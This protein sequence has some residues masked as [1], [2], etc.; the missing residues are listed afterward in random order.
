[1]G[2]CGKAQAEQNESGLPQIADLG[3]KSGYR[4]AAFARQLLFRELLACLVLWKLA[5]SM[6]LNG[7]F[8]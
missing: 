5:A 8:G 4:A 1:L 3:A 7:W 6:P 2:H